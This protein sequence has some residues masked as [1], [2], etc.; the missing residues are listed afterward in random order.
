MPAIIRGQT[1]CNICQK[2]I[3][4]DD[5]IVS[6]PAF[7]WNQHD[8]ISAFSDAVF[9][10]ACFHQHPLKSQAQERYEEL[11]KH[12][13][14]GHR[15]CFVCQNQITDQNQHVMVG[16]ITDKKD[17]FLYRFNNAQF[18]RECFSIWGEK[19]LFIENIKELDQSGKWGGN[20][21]KK[22]LTDLSKK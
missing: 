16:H 1:T 2:T 12:I 13:G 5:S 9:H 19:D 8:P 18:H 11:K 7:V 6:F 21:L 22:L 20:S 3:Q 10:E 15:E 14:P 4:S 17:E